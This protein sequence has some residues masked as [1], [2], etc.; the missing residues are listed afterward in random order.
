MTTNARRSR[1]RIAFAVIAALALLASV[2]PAARYVRSA[3]LLLAVVG[4]DDPT[5]ITHLLRHQVVARDATLALPGRSLRAR[6][7]TPL[8]RSGQPAPR[9]WAMVLHGVH[10]DGIDEPRLQAF[11]RALAATGVE[12]FT[13]ELEELAEQR[14]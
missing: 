13:P 8:D 7:Y 10:P 9:S 3:G 11:A 6:I 4:A 5:R 12:T 2:E 1:A 14:V